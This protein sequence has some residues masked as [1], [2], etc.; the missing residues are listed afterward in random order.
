[1]NRLISMFCLAA[2]VAIVLVVACNPERPI[3]PP[4]P[5]SGIIP[6]FPKSLTL[7]L[8]S[9]ES[10]DGAILVEVR[11]RSMKLVTAADSTWHFYS[12]LMGDTL[13]RAVI[14]GRVSHAELMTIELGDGGFE[15]SYRA[16]VIEVADQLGEVRAGLQNYA[17]RIV[18]NY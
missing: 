2:V 17:V 13:F 14:V 18:G 16:T 9:P 1:M 11:G 4:P 5:P 10:D 3:A 15:S 6:A 7:T 8:M 12:Q